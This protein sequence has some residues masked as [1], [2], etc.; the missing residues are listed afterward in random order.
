M[1]HCI[2]RSALP[3][4]RESFVLDLHLLFSISLL[5]AAEGFN[6]ADYTASLDSSSN[7]R[8][9]CF[10]RRTPEFECLLFPCQNLLI[11]SPELVFRHT[12]DFAGSDGMAHHA[13]SQV[14]SH[15]KLE[16]YVGLGSRIWSRF[17]PVD[18][19]V[20]SGAAYSLMAVIHRFGDLLR[21][22]ERPRWTRSCICEQCRWNP[23][24]ST[25]PRH[26]EYDAGRRRHRP[27]HRRWGIHVPRQSPQ[28]RPVAVVHS[29]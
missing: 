13:R 2:Y 12:I 29:G 21:R 8:V 20:G 9:C 19:R 5:S 15:R 3:R 10:F 6:T 22:W 11:S 16:R 7:P 1:C 17:D 27:Q 24:R 14:E 25:H 28:L 26:R 18:I 23:V 4:D